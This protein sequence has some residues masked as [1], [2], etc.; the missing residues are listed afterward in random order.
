MIVRTVPADRVVGTNDP[1]VY[2]ARL[3]ADEKPE[4]SAT[5]PLTHLVVAVIQPR[6]GGECRERAITRSYLTQGETAM[7]V[8]VELKFVGA[9][10]EQYDQ[11]IEKMGLRPGGPGAPGGLFHWVTKTDDGFRVVD[12]W[13]TREQ[14]E[15]FSL[16]QIGPFAAAV[17]VT[18]PP[19]VTFYD[20]HNYLTAGD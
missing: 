16:E 6:P 4:A 14:F 19:E 10:L 1:T 13:Q 5:K 12:V 17:G 7:A 15:Q 2:T 3:G 11:V 20:L 18:T 8:A 9:T